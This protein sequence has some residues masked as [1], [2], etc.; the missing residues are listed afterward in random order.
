MFSEFHFTRP[1]WLFAAGLI[2]LLWI[3]F[4]LYKR[5]AQPVQELENFI[6][7]HLLPYLLVN[8]S[9]SLRF[10]K[11]G[12]LV[13]TLVWSCLTVGL[14]GPRWNFREVEVFSRQQ[15]LVILLDL[16]L[17]MNATDVKP[18]RLARA[19]QKIEDILS[20]PH[21]VKIGLI[22]YA[23]DPH[24]I[25]PITDDKETIRH[26]LP[27]LDTSLVYV[28][29]SRLIPALEM[30]SSM[31]D[32]EPGTCKSIAILSDGG[33]E[34]AGAIMKAKEIAKKGIVIHTMG[35]GT[36]EGA[37]IV[38][39]EGRVKKKNGAP[40]ISKLEK[41]R[42]QEIS[43]AG[44][45]RYL[46]SE[47]S[48]HDENSIFEDLNKRV[49]EESLTNK[50]NRFWQEHFYLCI[51]PILPVFLLWFRRGKI[52]I[53]LPFIFS[54]SL[55]AGQIHFKNSEQR[56]LESFENNDYEKAA[57]EFEDPYR[58]GIAY[59]RAG[60][61]AEAEAMFKASSRENVALSSLYNLGN[62]LA[63]Q[64]KF[65]EAISAYEEVL[66]HRPDD[67][68]AKQN[69]EIVKKMLAEQK[70]EQNS[71][72]S[73]GDKDKEGQGDSEPSEGKDSPND[74]ESSE[75]KQSQDTSQENEDKQSQ[76]SH[77]T[78]KD[79][80]E[81]KEESPPFPEANEKTDQSDQSEDNEGIDNEAEFQN[82]QSE[83]EANQWLNRMES[84]PKAFMKNKFYIESKRNAVKEGIDPW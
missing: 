78:E 40:V 28:Q 75:G 80:G 52:F 84:D 27:S 39:H 11:R 38:D 9:A 66:D 83:E 33:F 46:K 61:F 58:K 18:S 65:K 76:D 1:L 71:S 72:G 3:V 2:P 7:N 34:D 63:Q 36:E 25:T 62:T 24:M 56:G 35:V 54:F 59:Y 22:A 4:F 74:S 49:N 23:A 8:Q 53:F 19:K 43:N 16:S 51:I 15:H 60:K 81:D 50:K 6:D 17:S 45:G 30:A 26:L 47:Y 69:L 48:Y 37:P 5:K 70:N 41:G 14:A 73:D 77:E 42:F 10:F 82:T 79:P 64:Q 20:S 31:L 57:E 21:G 67:P 55:N 44:N 13:W 32:V 68:K 12:L 29:G